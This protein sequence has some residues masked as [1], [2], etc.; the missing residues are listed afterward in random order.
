[1]DHRVNLVADSEVRMLQIIRNIEERKEEA[2][3][4]HDIEADEVRDIRNPVADP[5]DQSQ[6]SDM[7][8]PEMAFEHNNNWRLLEPLNGD[9][10]EIER[11]LP[12]LNQSIDSDSE[13]EMQEEEFITLK[14][15][16]L[17][18]RKRFKDDPTAQCHYLWQNNDI[19]QSLGPI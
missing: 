15:L 3:T 1:M 18:V 6:D 12:R 14:E 7:S 9:E 5:D 2:K 10:M 13:A 11:P 17:I 4:I 19:V 16:N 8:E